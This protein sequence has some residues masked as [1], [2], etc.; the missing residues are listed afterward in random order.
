MSGTKRSARGG[1]VTALWALLALSLLGFASV[2]ATYVREWHA[3]GAG[4]VSG[5]HPNGLTITAQVL[6]L[7]AWV[8]AIVLAVLLRRWGWLVVCVLLFFAAPVFAIAMLAEARSAAADRGQQASF[9]EAM[10]RAL[11]DEQAEHSKDGA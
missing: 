5:L 8:L 1:E 9:Q 10:A 7:A 4:N 11:A 2:V 3:L 6:L